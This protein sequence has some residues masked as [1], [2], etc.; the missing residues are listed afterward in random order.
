MITRDRLA[1][2][3]W[4]KGVGIGSRMTVKMGDNWDHT[5]DSFPSLVQG[6]ESLHRH[7]RR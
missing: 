5:M 6:A 1:V 3:G 4:G 2:D 7:Q